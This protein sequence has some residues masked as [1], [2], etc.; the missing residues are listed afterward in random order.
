MNKESLSTLEEDVQALRIDR[1]RMKHPEMSRRKWL[2]VLV[3]GVVL[4]AIGVFVVARLGWG[5]GGGLAAKEVQVAS[6]TRREPG[7]SQPILSAGG[8]VIARNQVEVGSKI[9]G[10]VVA[11]EVKEGDFVRQGQIIARLDD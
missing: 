2:L 5:T 8:Y 3:I 1:E 6:A 4:L 9:T 11:L 7:V 10:R